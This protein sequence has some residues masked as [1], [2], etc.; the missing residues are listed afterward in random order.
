MGLFES[1]SMTEKMTVTTNVILWE[2]QDSFTGNK[3]APHKPD[4]KIL[5]AAL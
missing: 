5:E 3:Y 2:K 1:L 4:Q